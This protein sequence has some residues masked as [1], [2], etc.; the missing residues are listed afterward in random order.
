MSKQEIKEKIKEAVEKDP[1]NKDILRVSL[2]GSF[3]YGHPREDS[4][5]DVLIEF[6]PENNI[7]FFELFDIQENMERHV[8]RKVDL[9]TPESISHFFRDKVLRQAEKIYEGK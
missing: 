2:F 4:D 5:V 3:V 8:N 1:H 7:G 9:L 6:K